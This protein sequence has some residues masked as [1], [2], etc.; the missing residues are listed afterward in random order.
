MPHQLQT[1][2]PYYAKSFI[3]YARVCVDDDDVVAM[4]CLTT[5]TT[6]DLKIDFMMYIDTVYCVRLAYSIWYLLLN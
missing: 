6:D 2:A 4:M 3:L 5:R 1:A